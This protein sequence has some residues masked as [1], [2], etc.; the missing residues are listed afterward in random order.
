MDWIGAMRVLHRLLLCLPLAIA[1]TPALADE[2]A[3][4]AFLETAGKAARDMGSLTASEK[5]VE[6]K[7]DQAT[8][9]T[10][11]TT[12]TSQITAT[13]SARAALELRDHR[14]NLMARV[15]KSGAANQTLTSGLHSGFYYLSVV[16]DA[17][18]TAPY[19]LDIKIANLPRYGH[20][21]IAFEM[22]AS[23][24]TTVFADRFPVGREETYKWAR[25]VLEEAGEMRLDMHSFDN[26]ASLQMA[27]F[28]D[29]NKLADLKTK[30]G[31]ATFRQNVQPGEFYVRAS[32]GGNG[33]V[34]FR[35]DLRMV[36]LGDQVAGGGSAGDLEVREPK[37]AGKILNRYGGWIVGTGGEGDKKYCYAY[38]VAT[39]FGPEG[40]RRVKPTLHFRVANEAS[41]VSHHFDKVKF[42][43]ANKPITAMAEINGELTEIPILRVDGSAED[44]RTLARCG[45]DD[46]NWCVS[47]DG[48]NGL[49]NGTRLVVTGTSR[50]GQPTK[51][52]YDLKGYTQ[53]MRRMTDACAAKTQ[54][55]VVGK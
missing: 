51:V 42:Y 41:G 3:R 11:S 4:K 38:T 43:D 25:F 7:L 12:T 33:D 46:A 15:N 9:Y 35:L 8:H 30:D 16:P 19:K 13:L 14:G 40:W 52:T 29:G 48:L 54:W 28:R 47:N 26:R 44:W 49:S 21:A 23:L 22:P 17:E 20:Y 5:T 32:N 31:I 10:F 6:G 36:S 50:S 2:A 34:Q 37:V 24:S 55:L 1:A 53:A 45:K 18:N 39:S 27:V